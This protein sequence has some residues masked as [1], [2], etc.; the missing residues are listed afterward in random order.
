LKRLTSN[1]TQGLVLGFF[2]LVWVALVAILAVAPEVYDQALRLPGGDRG[3]AALVFLAAIS[4]LIALLVVGVLRR[5]R[6]TFWLILVAFILS[7]ALRVP[8]SILQLTGIMST[9]LP[10]WYVLLQAFIGV[11]E[12]V[13]GLLML[14]GYRREGVWGSF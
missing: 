7:G 11:V 12:F 1:R 5:W 10:T 13:V 2:G 9:N 14:A 3:Q 8:A 4:C 6:W